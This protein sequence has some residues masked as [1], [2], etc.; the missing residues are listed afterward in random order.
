[1]ALAVGRVGVR[2][3]GV[4]V[5]VVVVVGGVGVVMEE[6]AGLVGLGS[7]R[8]GLWRGVSLGYI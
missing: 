1:M 5:G 2:L 4:V 3:L 6:G 7:G 8:R